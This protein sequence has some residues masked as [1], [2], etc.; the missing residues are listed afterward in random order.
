MEKRKSY[1]AVDLMK[2]AGSIM[3]IMIH[4]EPLIPQSE[5]NFFI[6]NIICRIAVPFFF[7]SSAFF[8][9]KGMQTRP[10]YLK[11]YLM[12]L[13]KSYILWSILFLPMGIDW[14]YQ[15]QPVPI[16]L[17]PAALLVGF[18]HIGTYYHLWYIPAFILSVV[19]I[20]NLLKR[21]SYQI[22]FGLSLILYLFGSLETYYGLLPSGWF[23]EFF[24][25]VIRLTFT[26]RN[27][28]FFGMIFTLI[29]FF[30]YDN[31][32]KLSRIEKHS[33]SFLWF[34]G[35]LFVLEGLWL[36]HIRRLDMNF[37]WML[38]P[39]SFFLFL[40]LL[41][42]KLKQRPYL[43]KLR[44]RSH[45]YYFIHPICIVLVEETGKAFKLSLLSYG[46]VSFLIILFLTHGFATVLINIRN[47]PPKL[48]KP[49]L[50]LKTLFT[51]IGITLILAGALYQFKVS[52]TV[53]KFEF[54]PC[55]WVTA[56][57]FSLF[58]FMK[59]RMIHPAVRN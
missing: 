12:R 8:L 33:T 28:L 35:S 58:F 25:L 11:K 55:T 21:F 10:E 7:V 49:A 26:T 6:K 1:P 52:S 50:L 2:Y 24:D 31:R 14:I 57:F 41:S 40:W 37:I 23:K 22:V 32:K 44:E 47:R 53:I 48:L 30:I 19:F 54:V 18:V 4:C 39:L 20:V 46:M 5:I 51:G 43:K 59:E 36:F 42:R 56:S 16:E 17:F 27:G 29:G 45:Y 38:V 13:L 9:R 34:F 15:N 3:V